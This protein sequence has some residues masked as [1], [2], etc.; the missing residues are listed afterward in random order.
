MRPLSILLTAISMILFAG[1][2]ASFFL[3]R[4]E[5]RLSRRLLTLTAGVILSILLIELTRYTEEGRAAFPSTL[6]I[7]T[8]QAFSLDSAYEAISGFDGESPGVFLSWY[9][10]VV[11]SIAPV[12][13]GAVIY[14]VLAGVSPDLRLFFSRRRRLC[15]FSE[16]NERSLTLAADIHD[17]RRQLGNPVIVFTDCYANEGDEV[18]SEMLLRAQQLR[19]ICLKT[20][21]SH[22]DGFR[23]A[24]DSMFFL[25]DT[26]PDGEFNDVE[27]L[28]AFRELLY[29]EKPLWNIKK[30]HQ[31]YAFSNNS[32][33]IDNFRA[34]AVPFSEDKSGGLAGK[35]EEYLERGKHLRIHVVRDYSLTCGFQ[36]RDVPLFKPLQKTLE[37]DPAAPREL[38]V[39][40]FGRNPFAAE[41]F[42]TVYWC[43]QVFD[44]T[45]RI[46]SVAPPET[47]DGSGLT[48]CEREL[49]AFNTEILESCREGSELLR[50]DFAGNF[51]R[52][53]ADL[54]FVEE[55]PSA[56]GMREFLLRP[57]EYRYGG[58]T[59]RLADCDYFLVMEE[60]DETNITLADELRRAL[61]Y[62]GGTE[63]NRRERV[64]AFLVQNETIRDIISVRFEEWKRGAIEGAG[65][66]MHCF[67]GLRE[68]FRWDRISLNA[69]YLADRRPGAAAEDLFAHNAADF[70]SVDDIY[71][72]WSRTTRFFHLQY[73]MYYTGAVDAGLGAFGQYREDLEEKA[74]VTA[75]MEAKRRYWNAIARFD[76]SLS[77]LIWMEHRRWCAF[78][79]IQGF[80]QPPR[81]LEKLAAYKDAV[82][83]K[84]PETPEDLGFSDREWRDLIVYSRKEVSTRLHSS[85]VECHLHA[86]EGTDD[87]LDWVYSLRRMINLWEN[88]GSGAKAPAP[89]SRHP[90]PGGDFKDYIGL[91]KYDAPLE[92]NAP[93]YTPM[94]LYVRMLPDEPLPKNEKAAMDELLGRFADL[95]DCEKRDA[96]DRPLRRFFVDEVESL[97]GA[98]ARRGD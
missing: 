57:R 19:S 85:L 13:G 62:L 1:S 83:A 81:L 31:I 73:K 61:Y 39:A 68:R 38:R 23:R 54:A 46:V 40:I 11:Y 10:A 7:D 79:R 97:Y 25:M 67:G 43:G 15:V 87:L 12:V 92:N 64:V 76:D 33:V 91:K 70:K 6:L 47:P 3:V 71:D 14:D 98:P 93:C 74:L 80:S 82:E 75:G 66:E 50:Q 95:A 69:D 49:N 27:N 21:I 88:P 18:A 24:N 17:R 89:K 45:L 35:N 30:H 34:A 56:C 5:T 48:A 77:A 55:D 22:C 90:V 2:V 36:L 63:E 44:H 16:L 29:A 52:P 86:D 58:G 65:P 4:R 32:T 84:R 72:V 41:M 28:A 26:G 94:E 78:L 42:K 9:R 37:K 96:D 60:S 59:F 20:D 51:S 8:L 53:Y